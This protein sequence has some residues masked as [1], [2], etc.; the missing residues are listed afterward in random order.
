MEDLNRR[1]L[2]KLG[3]AA[4]VAAV[5]AATVGGHPANAGT[6]STATSIVSAAALNVFH[7][8]QTPQFTVEFDTPTAQPDQLSYT[9]RSF[10]LTTVHT[11]TVPVPA[12]AASAAISLP[13]MNS[14][15][16]S[17]AVNLDGDA[18]ITADFAVVLHRT[19]FPDSP[20]ALDVAGSWNVPPEHMANFANVLKLSGVKWIRDRI[21]W[22]VGNN[23]VRGQF[24][25]TFGNTDEWTQLASIAGVKISLMYGT[26]PYWTHPYDPNNPDD[27]NGKK[28]PVYLRDAYD[29]AKNAAIYYSG[30]VQAWE[31]M[32]E[33]NAGSWTAVN[34]TAD[35][36]AAVLKAAAIG[37]ADSGAGPLVA[38]AGMAGSSPTPSEQWIRLML[39]NQVLD[40]AT[41]YNYHLHKIYNPAEQPATLPTG[42]GPYISLKDDYDSSA[43]DWL[44]EAGMKFP[45]S[46]GRR[47]T[48]AEQQAQ[49]RY[50]VRWATT[51]LA[52]GTD[53]HFVYLA[54]PTDTG[55][56]QVGLFGFDFT[57]YAGYAAISAMTAA[58]GEGKYRGTVP[59]LPSATGYVFADG[60][61]SVLVLWANTSTTV[62]IALTQTTAT[63]T[64]IMGHSS[65]ISRGTNGYTLTLSAEPIYLRVL[66][67]VPVDNPPEPPPTYQ[68]RVLSPVRR[69]VLLQQYPTAVS[70]TA[71]TSGY[72]LPT[73]SATTVAVKVYNFN[74]IA[75][76]GS[77]SG[78]AQGGW[79]LVQP[80]LP[81]T[82]AADGVATVNFSIQATTAVQP[83]VMVPVTFVGQFADGQT[84]PATTL[85]TTAT[86]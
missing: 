67:T 39:Q 32:N 2:L 43:A 15:H 84:S 76:T 62:T 33:S 23:P 41:I 22:S 6:P 56:G 53:R 21:G 29:W 48:A 64:N 36:Y 54:A 24:D 35:Q 79:Q 68:P 59:G 12:G 31:V 50:H 57:P 30:R 83:G 77:I 7:T 72:R 63:K 45:S 40:Y 11:G 27:P 18:P 26:S 78:T 82:V 70:G 37:Y 13:H 74:S 1:R 38:L 17:I 85:I 16:Y 10:W 71:R 44:T 20:V 51:S 46:M 19:V 65:Q 8:G 5:T 52:Q 60:Q 61:D 4:T 81:V 42:V 34:E 86:T 73:S 47:L 66:G 28:L 80:T 55:T 14:G 9:V 58:L 3:G 69:V 49:A 25:F 75:R